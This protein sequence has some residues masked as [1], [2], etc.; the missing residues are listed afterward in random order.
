MLDRLKDHR[1]SLATE[2]AVELA[3]NPVMFEG[4]VVRPVVGFPCL[5][6]FRGEQRIFDQ[7]SRIRLVE[8]RSRSSNR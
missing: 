2:I 1:N 4:R 3:G 6:I 7:R 8:V 5:V